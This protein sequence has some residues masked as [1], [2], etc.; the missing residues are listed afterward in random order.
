LPKRVPENAAGNNQQR[1]AKQEN[2]NVLASPATPV[3]G[4]WVGKHAV[5]SHRIGDV[6][7]LAITERF[8]S[9]NQFMLNL[10]V[11]AA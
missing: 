1:E 10:F 7:D 9:A 4:G 2:Q 8:V 3:K 6:L 5:N 11:N